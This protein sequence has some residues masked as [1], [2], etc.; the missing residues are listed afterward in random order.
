MNTTN[1]CIRL[2]VSSKSAY[3][4]VENGDDYHIFHTVL[5][6]TSLEELRYDGASISFILDIPFYDNSGGCF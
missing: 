2:I 4:Q 6:P 3:L 5:L 1:C